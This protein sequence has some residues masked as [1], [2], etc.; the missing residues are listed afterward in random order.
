VPW[1]VVL[2]GMAS[3]VFFWCWGMVGI[4]VVH[5]SIGLFISALYEGLAVQGG[6]KSFLLNQP[7]VSKIL[8]MV[9]Q[10]LVWYCGK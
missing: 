5:L 8:W 2:L 1:S 3:N 4:G 9:T 7:R 10:T 6:R